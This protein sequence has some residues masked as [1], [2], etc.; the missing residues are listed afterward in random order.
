M[1]S[2][3]CVM[4]V[5]SRCAYPRIA[6]LA[7]IGTVLVRS[8][9]YVG[10]LPTAIG[11][12]PSVNMSNVMRAFPNRRYRNFSS[13]CKECFEITLLKW[14]T[15]KPGNYHNNHFLPPR[16]WKPWKL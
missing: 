9:P 16:L 14:S 4:S 15:A 3:L 8:R 13:T 11:T 2:I 7:C 12:A 5:V 6:Q 10:M 1:F